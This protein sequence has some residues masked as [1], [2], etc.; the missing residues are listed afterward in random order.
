[1][2]AEARVAVER[3]DGRDVV[4]EMRSA[5]P[6]TLRATIDGVHLVG[7]GA[8]PLGGDR[9]R[10]GIRV[11]PGA[12]LRLASVAATMVQPGPHGGESHFVVAV[13]LEEE[14]RLDLR[15]QPAILV[16]GCD[17]HAT[18]RVRMAAGST[19]VWRDEVVLGRH[20]EDGGSALQRLDVEL[21]GRALLRTETALGGRWPGASGPAGVAAARVVGSLLLVGDD[22][23]LDGVQELADRYDGPPTIDAVPRAAGGCRVAALRL[24]GPGVLAIVVAERA[25][26]AGPVLDALAA[27][28]CGD[29]RSAPVRW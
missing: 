18:T 21:G 12:R 13:D 22:L 28:A 16:R 11:G 26:V 5:P 10:L 29:D 14:A 17:H 8:G 27:V 4:R 19:L 25:S 3:V 20:G 1:M 7:S 2:E 23:D 15:P 6:L 24:D 9:L